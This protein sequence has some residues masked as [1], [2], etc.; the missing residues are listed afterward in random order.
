MGGLWFNI[1]W[2]LFMNEF[3]KSVQTVECNL[4]NAASKEVP[5][6]LTRSPLAME[7]THT[8]CLRQV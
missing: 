3:E 6:L 7:E 2:F 1:Q 5:P 4:S 8:L